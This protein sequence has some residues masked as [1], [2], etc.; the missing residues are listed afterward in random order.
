MPRAR[1]YIYPEYP[2]YPETSVNHAPFSV[3]GYPET[4]PGTRKLGE[5]GGKV[6]AT[7]TRAAFARHLGVNKSTITRWAEAGRLVLDAAGH[8]I[9]E[10]SERRL[11]ATQGGRTDVAARHA[12]ERGLSIPYPMPSPKN[13]ASGPESPGVVDPLLDAT[14]TGSRQQAK[15]AAMRYENDLIKLEM[16][17]RRH[18]RYDAAA[19]TREGHALGAMTRA[20]MER[21]IDQLAPRL[22][23]LPGAGERRR[24]IELEARRL[25]HTLRREFPRAL[26]RLRQESRERKAA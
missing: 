10:A 20:A 23:A 6:S 26:R 9:I 18:L 12:A 13:G 4:K 8:V 5:K 11:V 22:V 1:V 19:V 25:R 17:L 7:M 2:E 16:A 21:L 14:P 24:V 15:A 3:S